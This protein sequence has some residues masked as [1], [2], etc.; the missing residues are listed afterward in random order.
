VKVFG[1]SIGCGHCITEVA[2]PIG[3]PCLSC[4][5]AIKEGDVGLIMPHVGETVEEKP[6]HIT[7]FRLA[8]G[9]QVPS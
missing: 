6:W 4:N 3:E 5:V 7:C 9:I 1:R 8:L 2:T